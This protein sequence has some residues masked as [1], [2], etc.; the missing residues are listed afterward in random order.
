MGNE[1]VEIEK[2]GDVKATSS[3]YDQSL[4]SLENCML[5]QVFFLS[6]DHSQNV[7]I[8]ETDEIDYEEILQRLKM[9]ESVFIKTKDLETLKR[10]LYT[11]KE[12]E[13]KS[14]YFNRF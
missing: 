2:N 1:I 14:L 6:N 3:I 11:E 5:F 13:M 7:E 8:V 9:G 10:R 4:F 12:E